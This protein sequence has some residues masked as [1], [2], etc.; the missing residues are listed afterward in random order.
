[1]RL[2]EYQAK[3]LLRQAGIAIPPSMLAG[4][5][6]QVKKV[7]AE[8]GYPLVLKAQTLGPGRGKAGGVRLVQ[9][10]KDI[11]KISNEVFKLIINNE[12]VQSILVEKAFTFLRE[13]Y[14]GIRT[15]LERG[16]PVLRVSE[17]GGATCLEQE[18]F[19][20]AKI[21]EHPIDINCGLKPYQIREQ[22]TKIDLAPKLWKQ[23]ENI[24]LKLYRIYR[25]TD[26]TLAEINS[27]VVTEHEQ[28]FVLDT[29]IN[30]DSQAVYRQERFIDA[31][32]LSYFG[33]SERQARKF[34]VTYH[35]FPGELACLVNGMGLAY[36]ILDQFIALNSIPAAI[37]DIHG[38]SSVASVSSS[39]EL[40][41]Q[42][43]HVKAI[44]INIFGG[45]TKCDEVAEG[46]RSA[47]TQAPH[48]KPIFLRLKGTNETLAINMLSGIENL[49][50]FDS[51]A[52]LVQ[53]AVS[54]LEGKQ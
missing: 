52:D 15:D 35:Y 44:V 28:L 12:P 49:Q 53:S 4:N 24:A 11:E 19:H 2:Q 46:I 9:N 10:E 32:N 5:A 48:K 1:M 31:F 22:L 43:E 29:K 36:L 51:T 23:F 20:N 40:L 26:A 25:S 8:I 14:L 45:M 3:G 13:Y 18:S 30:I 47:S 34:S 37:I 54:F 50:I 16:S 17:A 6:A 27:L 38:S 41:Y 39:L 42:E 7:A 33:W 21:S